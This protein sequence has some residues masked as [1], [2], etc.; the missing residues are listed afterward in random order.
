MLGTRSRCRLLVAEWWLLMGKGGSAHVPTC[1]VFTARA[2]WHSGSAAQRPA[3]SRQVSERDI[4]MKHTHTHTHKHNINMNISPATALIQARLE[5]STTKSFDNGNGN[6]NTNLGE[7][8]EAELATE[9]LY[10]RAW[11]TG[12]GLKSKE[13]NGMCHA[14][15]C[16]WRV[17]IRAAV[18]SSWP[19]LEKER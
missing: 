1:S 15:S 11:V 6:T 17:R 10:Q 12:C 2:G 16:L 9:F 4:H 13:Y 18:V 19:L 8:C 5:R 7:N 3:F 14:Q